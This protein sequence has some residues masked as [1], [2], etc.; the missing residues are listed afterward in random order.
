MNLD[1]D[2][3]AQPR[4]AAGVLFFDADDRVMLVTPTYKADWDIPGGG[5]QPGETP[6]EGARREVK[7]ELGVE[8]PIGRLLVVD[9]APLEGVGDKV[10][11][12][13]DGGVL[14]EEYVSALALAPD[15]IA[16]YTFCERAEIADHTLAR[17]TRRLH[18]ALDA[19]R[20]GRTVYLE[21][22]LPLP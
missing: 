15:E 16:D 17:M 7:E 22:G 1:P 8:P 11:F 14:A 20:D 12:V 3:I 9:W 13:F 6:L 19:R 10:L 4:T 2:P 21:H 5:V 18:A